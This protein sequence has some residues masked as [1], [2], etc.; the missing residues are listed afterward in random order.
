MRVLDAA[1]AFSLTIAFHHVSAAPV[2]KSLGP[3]VPAVQAV[4]A[5]LAARSAPIAPNSIPIPPAEIHNRLKPTRPN[6]PAAGN[7]GTLTIDGVTVQLPAGC[8]PTTGE[9]C[10]PTWNSLGGILK[11]VDKVVSAAVGIS[12]VSIGR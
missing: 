9:G 7:T 3:A 6:P 8:S 11:G 10:G 1:L 5:A 12:P 4:S 2:Q